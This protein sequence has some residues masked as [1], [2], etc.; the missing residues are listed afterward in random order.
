MDKVK[1]L[2]SNGPKRVEATADSVTFADERVDMAVVFSHAEMRE[3]MLG[4]ERH[5]LRETVEE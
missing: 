1:C 4:W 3:I 5:E 2:Y